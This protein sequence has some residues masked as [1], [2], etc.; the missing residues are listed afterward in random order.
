MQ[1]KKMNIDDFDDILSDDNRVFTPKPFVFEGMMG[2]KLAKVYLPGQTYTPFVDGW[3]LKHIHLCMCV[4]LCE[5]FSNYPT[6]TWGIR[7]IPKDANC[8]F[9]GRCTGAHLMWNGKPTGKSINMDSRLVE[10]L[11]KPGKTR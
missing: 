3:P 6:T 8:P 4:H 11:V 2:G 9:G 10:G 1:K 5:Q 7:C